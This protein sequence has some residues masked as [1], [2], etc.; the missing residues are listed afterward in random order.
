MSTARNPQDIPEENILDLRTPKAI[1][2]GGV[3]QSYGRPAK[4][5]HVDFLSKVERGEAAIDAKVR[6][7]FSRTPK[8]AAPSPVV[9]PAPERQAVVAAAPVAASM[10]RVTRK[11]AYPQTLRFAAS[12]A[13]LV[14]AVF[15][16]R[17]L[18]H[19]QQAKGDVLGASTEALQRLLAASSAAQAL[20]FGTSKNELSAAQDAFA[21]AEK[22]LLDVAGALKNLPGAG[23]VR[24]AEKFLQAGQAVTRAAGA[25]A[26]GAQA[27]TQDP[28]TT[29]PL[30]NVV[31]QLQKALTPTVQDLASA[32]TLLQA[33]RPQDVPKDYQAAFTELQQQLPALKVQFERMASVGS[34]FQAFLATQ[35]TSKRYLFAFQN[36]NELRPTGGFLGSLA[37]AEMTNGELTKIEVPSGGVYDVSGQTALRAIAPQ[38]LQ[39]VQANWNL[40]DANWFPD[41]PTSAKK[42]LAYYDSAGGTPVD[43]VL[44][45]TPAVLQSFLKLTGPVAVPEVGITFTAENFVTEV[46][47]AIKAAEQKDY[48]KPKLVLGY[49]APRILS[50][51]FS[52]TQQQLWQLLGSMQG[53]LVSRDIQFYFT[54]PATQQQALDLGWAGELRQSEKDFL[55]INRA[56]LAGGK[57]DGVIEEVTSHTAVVAADGTIT[58]TVTII[59]KHNGTLHDAFTGDRNNVYIRFYVPNG[60]TLLNASGFDRIDPK[61][62]R[63]PS[64]DYL[65][66]PDLAAL[67]TGATIHETSGTR[68]STEA[69]HTVFGNW[70]GVAPGEVVKATLT[71]TLPFKLQVGGFFSRT[72]T[73]SL[74]VQMQAGTAPGF[75]SN[76]TLPSA[77]QSSWSGST[78]PVF[79]KTS[80]ASFR[81][82][83]DLN[84]DLYYGVVVKE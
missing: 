5:G 17:F 83:G 48:T 11:F 75:T 1:P 44:A 16:A 9:A 41:F 34:F 45:V 73:Y 60:S 23:Q 54:N 24:S 68:V 59:R 47:K 4:R 20:E 61:R 53:H 64:P 38:P 43:G 26:E 35:G 62:F 56:N 32:A 71:Y 28:G 21:S 82:A 27:L 3:D 31:A 57:T 14:L 37:I 67:E 80:D 69:G 15:A 46:Q 55:H 76:L 19:V 78:A 8:V 65:P 40:Q 29:T 84:K 7:W 2:P 13:V 36:S 66:D 63:A 12:V 79:E 58:D 72:D 50:R 22:D 42:V 70:L 33:V 25:L 10:P 39:L 6:S 51:A 49:L 81:L 77:W 52:L 74:L 18:G 30:V